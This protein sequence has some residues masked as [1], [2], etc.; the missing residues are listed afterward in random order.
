MN[1][2]GALTLQNQLALPLIPFA[3]DTLARLLFLRAKVDWYQIPDLVTLLATFALFCLGVMFAVNP[4]S[5]P[6]DAAAAH[7]VELVRR[8]LLLYSIAAIMLAGLV[9][10][11]RAFDERYPDLRIHEENGIYLFGLV[12]VFVFY[13]SGVI[14]RRCLSYVNQ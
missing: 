6:G 7:N 13:I 2:L 3:V 10:C 4:N 14:Y 5:L 12:M 11:F 8:R 9:S 1:P